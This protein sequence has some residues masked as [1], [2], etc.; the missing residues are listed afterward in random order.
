M[1][2]KNTKKVRN[3]EKSQKTEEIAKPKNGGSL[4]ANDVL[5]NF[6]KFNVINVEPILE[7]VEPNPPSSFKGSLISSSS[8]PKIVS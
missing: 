8:F 4:Q 1:I 2:L 7:R 6:V 3:C 5:G